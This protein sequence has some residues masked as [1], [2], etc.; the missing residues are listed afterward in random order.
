VNNTRR[1]NN[2]RKIRR[3]QDF[4]LQSLADM[5]GTSKSYIHDLETGKVRSPSLGRARL[6]AMNL[7][8]T[9]DEVF[10]Q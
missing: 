6:I 4:T 1:P 7:N 9:V 5:T 2:V 10:P 8:S 3:A